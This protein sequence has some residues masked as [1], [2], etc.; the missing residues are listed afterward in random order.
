MIERP[1]AKLS[2]GVAWIGANFWSRAGGPLMWRADRF[3]EGV[4]RGELEVLARHGLNVTRSFFYWPDFMPAEDTL[5]EGCIARYGRFLDLS[6][7][8]G[9]ATIPTFIVGHMSGENWDPPWR[10][11][12]DIYVDGT[13]LAQQAFFV[14]ELAARFADHPAVV[15]WLISNEI[16]LYGGVT[17]PEGGRAWADLM[18]QAVRAAGA[19]QPVSLG[20]GAWGIEVSGYDNGFRVRDMAKRVDFVGPHVYPFGDDFARQELTA[21][22]T[23]E[24]AHFGKPVVLEEFGVTTDFTSDAHAGDYYRHVLHGTLLAGASGWV[25]WNNTDFDLVEQDPYR[26]HA[27][28]LHFGVTRTDGTPKAPLLELERFAKVVA[29]ADLARCRRAPADVALVVSSYLEIAYPFT[30]DADRHSLRDVLLQ[31]YVGARLADLAPAI[32]R[33]VDGIP[34]TGARLVLVPC[35]KRLTAPGWNAL[36]E[37][38]ARGAVVYVSYSSGHAPHRGPWH[39]RFDAFFGI[40]HGLRYG[41][42]ESLDPAEREVVLRF[43]DSFGSLAAGDEIRV[44]VAGP[45]EIRGRL[46]LETVEAR[47]VARDA[48]GRPALVERR[49][50]EGAIVLATI[51]LE[52]FAAA[53]PSANSATGATYRLY[54]ALGA[55][56]SVARPVRVP[57]GDVFV[58]RLVRDDG[59]ELVFIV[60][61]AREAITIAPEIERGARLVDFVSGAVL[62]EHLDLAACGVA[63]AR[64][65]RSS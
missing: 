42:I 50:G 61:L 32:V 40:R 64:L 57:R 29:A 4:I 16:P 22:F 35:A 55:R 18:I 11:G 43:E 20:D 53:T 34:E 56:A 60:S 13:M 48:R 24:L 27:F 45:A 23:C 36:E 3:D 62:A 26:H 12:R 63:V 44:P 52:H 9:I 7:E 33:E 19:K 14:R 49:V 37:C 8:V 51:P 31:S 46:P 2:P 65:E 21:A 30:A 54:D 58:D 17:S 41:L 1:F 38:A 39:P 6:A 15:G 47:V 59:A 25:A 10:R 5:D 28:E